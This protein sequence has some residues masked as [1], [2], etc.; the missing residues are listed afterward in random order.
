MRTLSDKALEQLDKHLLKPSQLPEERKQK[1]RNAFQTL[2]RAD[3]LLAPYGAGLFLDF[4]S[5]PR[6]GPNAFALPGGQVILLDE[7][8][9]L[10]EDDEELLAVL[11]HELGHLNGRHSIRLLIQSSAVAAVAAAWFGDVSYALTAVSAALLNSAYSRDMEREADLYAGALLRRLGKSPARLADALE[12]METFYR[13]KRDQGR[14][15]ENYLDWL[16]SHPGTGERIRRLREE[17]GGVP[18][19]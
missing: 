9:N 6:I 3:A 13:A 7:L 5:A 18:E 16:S 8:A 10:C 17:Q 12:R 1:L 19:T 15:G 14:K 2:S 11:A 4:R